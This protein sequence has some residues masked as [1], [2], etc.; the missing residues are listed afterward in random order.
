MRRKFGFRGEVADKVHDF[1]ARNS[2][3]ELSGQDYFTVAAYSEKCH[4]PGAMPFSECMPI[5]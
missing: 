4:S 5:A 3:V 1:R 2:A